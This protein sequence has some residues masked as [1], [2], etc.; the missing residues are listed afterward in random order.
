MTRYTIAGSDEEFYCLYEP[1]ARYFERLLA[2]RPADGPRIPISVDLFHTPELWSRQSQYMSWNA[3]QADFAVADLN[4]AIP[5]A[6][7]LQAGTPQRFR[8]S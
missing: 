2:F 8:V 1:D 7:E 4:A 5:H 6:R 3:R